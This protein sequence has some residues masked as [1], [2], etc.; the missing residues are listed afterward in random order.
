[1][2]PADILPPECFLS[3]L[4]Y[5]PARELAQAE[6]V[7][8]GWAMLI[9]ASDTP[10]WRRLCYAHC[11][12]ADV[13]RGREGHCS[14][15]AIFKQNDFSRDKLLKWLAGTYSQGG[16]DLLPDHLA[17]FSCETWGEILDSEL[18]RTVSTS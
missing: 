18:Q 15:R 2:D 11:I 10:L 7:S 6:R 16:R 14:W 8:R 9:A 3:I 17:S 4:T 1:M 12:R 5:L 13:E